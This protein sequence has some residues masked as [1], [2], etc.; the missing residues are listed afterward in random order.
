M[1]SLFAI[2]V[3]L[4][5]LSFANDFYCISQFRGENPATQEY[6]VITQKLEVLYEDTETLVLNNQLQDFSFYS[7]YSK[8]TQEVMLQIIN[9]QNENYGVLSA[10]V[11]SKN[12][13]QKLSYV[14]GETVYIIE[15]SL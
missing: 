7:T 2:L 3:F 14:A 8:S 15:C 10:G 5:S 12:R 13:T 4:P 11:M 9:S 1:K 6:E